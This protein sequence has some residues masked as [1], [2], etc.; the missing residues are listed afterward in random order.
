MKNP[1]ALNRLFGSG[2]SLQNLKVLKVVLRHWVVLQI[3]LR[4]QGNVGGWR[5]GIMQKTSHALNDRRVKWGWSWEAQSCQQ[6]ISCCS[7]KLP[8]C[9]VGFWGPTRLF[10]FCDR[11]SLGCMIQIS[12]R[13]VCPEQPVK[14]SHI[15][16]F[17]ELQLCPKVTILMV[18]FLF[19]A[20][21]EIWK[22]DLFVFKLV[23]K[24]RILCTS[25]RGL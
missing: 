1:A 25:S 18:T 17:R 19:E 12:L 6:D 11:I 20:D 14:C 21:F 2:W 22:F 9:W 23:Q 8:L 5:V 24:F 15:K 13:R 7:I 3:G 16:C 10:I 4:P